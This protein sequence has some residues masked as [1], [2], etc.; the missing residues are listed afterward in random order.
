[1]LFLLIS[2]F[3][4][5]CSAAEDAQGPYSKGLANFKKGNFEKALSQFEEAVKTR[6]GKAEAHYYIGLTLSRLGRN[7]DAALALEKAGELNPKLPGLHLNL[8][9]AYYKLEAFEPALLELSRELQ[10]DPKNGSAHLF[11]GLTYQGQGQYEKS[12]PFLEKARNLDP[13]FNQLSRYYIGIA[14]YKA[15]RKDAARD[16]FKQAVDADPHSDTAK[17][18][19]DFLNTMAGKEKVKKRWRIKADAGM[20]YDDNLTV[21][22][23]DA[24]SGVDDWAAVFELEGGYKFLDR[25]PFE[26]EITYNFY[27]SVYFES[28]GQDT[29]QINTHSHDLG[30]SGGVDLD[31]WDIGLDYDYSFMLLGGDSFLQTHS[32]SPSVGFLPLP[33]LY[34]NL[35]YILEIKDFLQEEDEPRDGLNNSGGFDVFLFFME[36]KGYVQ[37]G[38]RLEGEDT[39]GDEFDYLGHIA[40][41]AV[42]VP[43]PFQS[44]VRFMYRYRFK[45][46]LHITPTI[47]EERED[48]RHTFNVVVTKEIFDYFELKVDYEHIR[49]DS[50]LP[51]VD[52][53][54][55]VIYMGVSFRL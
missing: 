37:L 18:A 5:I 9:I 35:S 6:P 43:L 17:D 22:E 52:Y 1:M 30:L 54:E 20:E 4:N 10:K 3:A 27:Q 2:F 19:Q 42:Q 45:D 36:H 32:I 34:I 39:S 49:S 24:A 11:M 46:Y 55:N 48:N 7:D 47:G 8:G 38:Y 14:H 50:N 28:D 26:G 31:K 53:H 23:R 29:S 44:K 41:C 16:A 21:E 51:S 25:K 40:T 13:D 12:I 33:I 15:G